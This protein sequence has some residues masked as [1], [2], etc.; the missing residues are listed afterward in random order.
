MEFSPARLLEGMP[1][2][3]RSGD[4]HVAFS[5]GLDSSVLLHALVQI[6]DRIPAELKVIHIHHGLQS[7]A[8]AWGEHCRNFAAACDVPYHQV[9]LALTPSA[10]ESIEALAREGR[11]RVLADLLQPDDWLLTAQHQDD[12]AET[13]LLQLLRGSGPAGLAAM[14]KTA[15]LGKGW[16]QRPLLG[17]TRQVLEAYAQS[18]GLTWVEDPSN[19]DLEFSRNYLRHKIMPR[20]QMHWPAASATLSRSAGLCADA[21]VLI[22]ELAAEDMQQCRGSESGRL[23][24]KILSRLSEPR[25]RSLLRH[26]VREQGAAAP[27][28][29]HLQRMLDECV[30]GR[31]DASPL[32]GWGGMEVRR[33]RDDLFLGPRLL[34]HDAGLCLSWNGE[35]ALTLPS[36]LGRLEVSLSE[37]GVD[38]ETWQNG[39]IEVRFRQGGERCRPAGDSFHRSLKQLFQT[40][41]VP[42]WMRDRI[43]LIFLDGELAVIS[44]F[45]VCQPFAAAKGAAAVQLYWGGVVTPMQ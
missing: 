11:Y 38:A 15:R 1:P 22:D 33:Y 25:I 27:G 26:W 8:D 4:C 36:G 9:N 31:A 30:L 41:G 35:A 6:R 10:G 18:K 12:Q 20:I 40:W 13:L 32:V 7:E 17:F 43:P 2:L 44:G 14:A 3:P 24:V 34:P 23:S 28:Y 39:R 21:Q 42:P 37:H 19:R 45:A 5:G 29:R 16:L